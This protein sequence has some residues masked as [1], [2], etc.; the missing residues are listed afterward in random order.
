MSRSYG[1]EVA[2][3]EGGDFGDVEPLGDGD[4]CGVG[5]AQREVRV[6]LDEFGHTLVIFNLEINDRYGLLH[7]RP[8]KEA[9]TFAP[10]TRASR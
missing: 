7:N 10:P 8:E 5:G 6:D 2:V 1:T 4:D 3:I 9:S